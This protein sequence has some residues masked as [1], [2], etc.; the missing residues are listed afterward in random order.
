MK[1]SEYIEVLNFLRKK[2]HESIFSD[3]DELAL[4]EIKH[5][6]NPKKRLEIYLKILITMARTRSKSIAITI[7][8]RLAN[9]LEVPKGKFEGV[10][11]ALSPTEKEI[12]GISRYSL[13]DLKNFDDFISQLEDILNSLYNESGPSYPGTNS[14]P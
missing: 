2:V 9:L 11:I 5:I 13:D 10:E 1:K 12:Y 3:I 7:N 14:E 4:K 8:K 6:E